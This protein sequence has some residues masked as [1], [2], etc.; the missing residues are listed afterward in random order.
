ML[1]GGKFV[2]APGER[3]T[4]EQG[5]YHLFYGVKG[6]GKVLV[7]E[8]NSVNDDIS[9]KYFYKQEGCFPEIEEDVIPEYL[10]VSDYKIVQ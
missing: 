9:D 3:I 10:L 4:F 1:P 2:L 5:I 6:M 7:G 8:V